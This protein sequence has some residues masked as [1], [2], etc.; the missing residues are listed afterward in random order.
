[1]SKQITDQSY[2]LIPDVEDNVAIYT[3]KAKQKPWVDIVVEYGKIGLNVD[4]ES[5]NAKLT[6]KYAIKSCPKDH[7][8]QKLE[9]NKDFHT[10]LGDLLAYIIQSAFDS[11]NYKVGTPDKSSDPIDV[12]S[13]SADGPAEDR[14]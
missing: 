13:T 9:Q 7:S 11:G 1:M 2:E 10:F 4:E 3:V 5:G 8:K 14:P 6:F 12:Q